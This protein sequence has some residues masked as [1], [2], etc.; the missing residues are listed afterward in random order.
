MSG[1]ARFPVETHHENVASGLALG[2]LDET[3]D[4]NQA[5]T[6]SC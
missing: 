4:R 3:I 6:S 2:G 5:Q 1:Q